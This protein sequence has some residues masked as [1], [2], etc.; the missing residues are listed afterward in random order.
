M[1]EPSKHGQK[2]TPDEVQK[3]E[4]L[5]KGNMPTR[6]IA[7]KLHR[8]PLAVESISRWGQTEFQ[9]NLKLGLTPCPPITR[10]VV[11]FFERRRRKV[12]PLCEKTPIFTVPSGQSTGTGDSPR[13]NQLP[14][15]DF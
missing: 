4:E 1:A 10:S 2:W 15:F 8:T 3:L 13:Y 5:A 14:L 6:V 12:E 7:L 11:S 9:V